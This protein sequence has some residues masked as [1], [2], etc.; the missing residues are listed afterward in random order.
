[1]R[2]STG[3]GEKDRMGETHMECGG[4][5]GE[6]QGMREMETETDPKAGGQRW[7]EEPCTDG[8][9]LSEAGF[10][11]V[12]LGSAQSPERGRTFPSAPQHQRQHT[13]TSGLTGAES[14]LRLVLTL[15]CACWVY[16]LNL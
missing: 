10:S 5:E 7:G 13:Q 16:S 12:V 3:R 6:T 9:L 11:T 8:A 15:G 4:W 2:T 14:W 1:M